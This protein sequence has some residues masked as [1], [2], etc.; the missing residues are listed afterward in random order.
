MKPVLTL[1]ETERH[2]TDDHAAAARRRRC[3]WAG[4]Q[5]ELPAG[6][7]TLREV[8]APAIPLAEAMPLA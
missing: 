3:T 4:L 5:V 2:Y 1:A 8:R 6:V 7:G